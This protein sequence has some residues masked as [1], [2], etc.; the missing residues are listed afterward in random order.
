MP[1]LPSNC[2]HEFINNYVKYSKWRTILSRNIADLFVLVAIYNCSDTNSNSNSNSNLDWYNMMTRKQ[3]NMLVHNKYL[4]IGYILIDELYNITK[5]INPNKQTNINYIE[6]IDTRIRKYNLSNYMISEYENK[7]V[8][9]YTKNYLLPKIIIAKSAGYWIKYFEKFNIHNI[10][11][12]NNFIDKL[13]LNMNYMD[14]YELR[15]RYIIGHLFS[16]L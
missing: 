2:I 16:R 8:P 12:L 7:Y 4:I 3:Y 13:S 6:Y 1:F 11:D 15:R 9:D 5:Q 14:W 10:K